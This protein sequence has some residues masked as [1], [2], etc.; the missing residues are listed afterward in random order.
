M[1][2]A[3]CEDAILEICGH[4][5]ISRYKR[6]NL[7]WAP[8]SSNGHFSGSTNTITIGPK[9]WR[10]V[11]LCFI[12]E[13][14]HALDYATHGTTDHSMRFTLILLQ[15]VKYWYDG[16]VKAYSWHTEYKR[17]WK[18]AK[19]RGWTDQPYHL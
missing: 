14:A 11:E 13:M 5:R 4:F 18:S 10:G 12:H 6:P 19:S 8:R 15:L 9:A 1:N 17:I 2:E 16:D 7:N 3:R